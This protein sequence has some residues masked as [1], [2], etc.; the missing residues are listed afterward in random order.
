[1]QLDIRLTESAE[2]G[3]LSIADYLAADDLTEAERIVRAILDAIYSLRQLPKRG[4]P[5]RVTDTL[6]LL[7]PGLPYLLVYTV[8]PDEVCIVQVLHQKQKWP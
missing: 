4:R 7:V 1:M 5:G 3:L 6:E 2:Q 8:M